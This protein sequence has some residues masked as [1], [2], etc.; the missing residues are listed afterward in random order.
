MPTCNGNTV[1]PHI[2]NFQSRYAAILNYRRLK[3]VRPSQYAEQEKMLQD[4]W[5]VGGLGDTS[6]MEHVQSEHVVSERHAEG[7]K[8]IGLEVEEA[9]DE[10]GLGDF[11]EVELFRDVG[12][13]GLECL[14]GRDLSG[15]SLTGSTIS[16]CMKT[17]FKMYVTLS[18]YV[19]AHNQLVL[20]QKARG[21][22]R[23]CPIGKAR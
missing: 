6:G 22:E 14:V 3:P 4:I 16:Q 10:H 15:A 5:R 7:W 11:L 20:E 23:Q 2:H 21:Q 8:R 12:E 18:S 17:A 19:M 13:L 9:E 1:E